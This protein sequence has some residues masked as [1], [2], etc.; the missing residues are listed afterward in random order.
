MASPS[1]TRSVYSQPGAVEFS[2]LKVIISNGIVKLLARQREPSSDDDF[3]LARTKYRHI[4]LTI[5]IDMNETGKP[6]KEKAIYLAHPSN[7]HT[8][9]SYLVSNAMRR[10]P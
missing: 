5:L 1:V 10:P 7:S 4:A 2:D 9:P 3:I 6:T 8:P